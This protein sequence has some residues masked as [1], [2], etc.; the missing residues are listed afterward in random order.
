EDL[1]QL[2]LYTTRPYDFSTSGNKGIWNLTTASTTAPP[3]IRNSTT[4][5]PLVKVLSENLNKSTLFPETEKNSVEVSISSPSS[6]HLS[7]KTQDK[8]SIIA[9][10]F[11]FTTPSTFYFEQSASGISPYQVSTTFQ[12]RTPCR[13]KGNRR[14]TRR[15]RKNRRDR[16]RDHRER[17]YRRRKGRKGSR[18]R[19]RGCRRRDKN[20][21]RNNN[22][23][24]DGDSQ[25]AATRHENSAEPVENLITNSSLQKTKSVPGSSNS[26]HARK[27]TQESSWRISN[28]SK[29]A[30]NSDWTDDTTPHF[31]NTPRSMAAYKRA[32]IKQQKSRN[33]N[34]SL[35]FGRHK[36]RHSRSR[37]FTTSSLINRKSYNAEK[38][39]QTRSGHK[40]RWLERRR[41][42]KTDVLTS[43][44]AN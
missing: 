15:N 10:R 18:L 7:S 32:M 44:S 34:T 2:G 30:E 17:K 12:E 16:K 24:R 33:K 41:R 5:T 8:L 31:R 36:V 29:V 40:R 28:D 4:I 35:Y 39:P 11:H 22:T 26:L 38:R 23:S 21:K 3:T 43:E 25:N 27:N 42:N 9:T 19:R 20:R 6:I 37:K 14:G 1:E 13:R